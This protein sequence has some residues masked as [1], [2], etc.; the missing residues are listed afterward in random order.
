[1]PHAIEI[2]DNAFDE[3]QAIKV[4]YRRQILEAIDLQL[5]HDPTTETKNRKV[6]I[7][8]QARFEHSVPLWELRVGQYR[9]YYDVDEGLQTVVIR[10]VR[11]KPPHSTTEETI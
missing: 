9:V 3:L 10:A 7:G 8:L 4:F 5:A 2:A 6:L 11:Q 1:M